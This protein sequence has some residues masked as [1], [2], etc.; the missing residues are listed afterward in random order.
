VCPDDT[1]KV[2]ETCDDPCGGRS[3]TTVAPV[4]TSGCAYE[5][6][7]LYGPLSNVVAIR[8]GGADVS[9]LFLADLPFSQN[10]PAGTVL[11]ITDT[12]PQNKIITSLSFEVSGGLTQVQ[13][14]IFADG[15]D[16]TPVYDEV[17]TDDDNDG[18]MSGECEKV[19]PLG[20][21]VLTTVDGGFM[22]N[23]VIY[24]CV[25][26]EETTGPSSG[27]ST[28]P[29]S[30]E[31]TGPSSG[32]STGPSSGE[33]TGPSSGEST[34]PSS[35][36][37]TGPSS[38]ESTGP[39]GS[40]CMEFTPTDTGTLITSYCDD[41]LMDLT[42]CVSN[43]ASVKVVIT[44]TDNVEMEETFDGLDGSE[45]YLTSSIEFV[46]I[47]TI[48][49]IITEVYDPSDA[50]EICGVEVTVCRHPETT[51]APQGISDKCSYYNYLM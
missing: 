25:S 40:E 44:T 43:A 21:V 3:A 47:G 2:T 30:G 31:S 8:D 34:G 28:G 38:G 6:E 41:I 36:E 29:S 27:E 13:V 50:S 18:T 11:E 7:Y 14:Q 22:S 5:P 42:F 12:R 49:I 33:S 24:V 9:A 45:I 32:E 35:G 19:I 20:K 16:V 4:T 26:P 46:E 10:T 51:V 39:S 1:E 15:D 37:S 48:E 23:V 17:W